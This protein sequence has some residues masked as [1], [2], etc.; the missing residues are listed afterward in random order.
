L[1]EIEKYFIRNQV[2]QRTEMLEEEK[3]EEEEKEKKKKKGESLC[4]QMIPLLVPVL[5]R[6]KTVQAHPSS[7]FKIILNSIFPSESRFSKW[8][9]TFRVSC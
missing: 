3:E 9:H 1:E 5:N 7:F 8:S 2:P 6:M 4:F